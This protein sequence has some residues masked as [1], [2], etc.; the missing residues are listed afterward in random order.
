MEVIDG[1]SYFSSNEK[2]KSLIEEAKEIKPLL[3]DKMCLISGDFYGIQKFIFDRLA[4]KNASKV[5]RAKSAFVQ[6]FTEFL[7]EY[8]CNELSIDSKYILTKNAGKFEILAPMETVD[9][10]DSIQKR[11]D[12]YFINNF[13]GLSGVMLS[14][15]KCTK[16]NF[17]P[18]ESYK[19]FRRKI[20]NS[21]EDK[22]FQKFNLLS[23][24]NVLKYDT[25]IDN[26]T[27]C[28]ICNIR[29]I[30]KDDK[31]EI[32]N[33]FIKLGQRLANKKDEL[34]KAKDLG[35][36]FDGF[37]PELTLTRKIKSYVLYKNESPVDFETL[38]KNSCSS[39][40]DQGV[41]ALAIVKADVDNMGKFLENSEVTNNFESFDAFSKTMDNFFSLYVP[42]IMEND[43]PNTYT[44]FA[45]GDD[46]FL[47]G[48]WDEILELARRIEKEFKEFIEGDTLSISFGIAL[49]K[50]STPISYLAEYT[51]KLLEEAKDIDDGEEV[52]HPKDAITLFDET[53]KWD[54]YKTI[55]GKLNKLFE[56][57][58]TNVKT[59]LYSY[60]LTFCK[61]AKNINKDI[62]N[63]MWKSK[64]NYLFRRNIDKRFHHILDELDESIENHPE[65]TKMFLSEF[66]Y[67]RRDR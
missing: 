28:K 9:I 38:A 57:F 13:Y 37:N 35:I 8:I 33:N 43:Y 26:Q 58:D 22:K 42:K 51:E 61:M 67:K 40:P 31:C 46:L 5:V 21:V 65:A 56:G 20:I 50:P 32:C 60:L 27:L 52:E 53:V 18:G 47:L 55:Y 30:V 24:S 62:R 63:T 6:I 48:A 39:T 64:L 10:I 19:K 25:N 34:V 66:I 14:C 49:A 17:E 2:F 29:K 45:G 54:E 41:E 36:E 59:T 15:V 7:A 44:V 16:E 23:A 1:M 12:N 4:T 3:K 11:I